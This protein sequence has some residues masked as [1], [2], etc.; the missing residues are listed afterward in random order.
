MTTGTAPVADTTDVT[1]DGTYRVVVSQTGGAIV[2]EDD[3]DVRC[4]EVFGSPLPR[5]EAPGP[6]GSLVDTGVEVARTV[7]VGLAA[8]LVGFLA[9][10]TGRRRLGS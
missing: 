10:R 5:P 4:I 8:I 3:V 9:V 6:S 2:A 7:G 1:A